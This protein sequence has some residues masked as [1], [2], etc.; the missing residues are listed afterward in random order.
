LKSVESNKSV[1]VV[2]NHL[3][4]ITGYRSVCEGLSDRL[5]KL[6]WNVFTTS[7]KYGRI[8]RLLDMLYTAWHRCN[9]Y[10]VATIDVFSGPAFWAVEL[11]SLLLQKLGKPFVLILHGGNL[12]QFASRYPIRVSRVLD[13]AVCVTSPSRYLLE[14]MRTFHSDIQLIPNPIDLSLYEFKVR[15]MPRPKLIWLRA[16]H[17]IYNPTLAPRILAQL[18]SDSPNT[19]LIMLGPDKGDGSLQETKQIANELGVLDRINFTGGVPKANVPKWLNEGDILINT[20]NVDNTPVSVIEAMACGLCVVSTDVGGIPYLLDHESD[21]LLVPP[22]NPK[23][24]AKAIKRI[25]NEP[26]LG[27]NLS[28]NARKKVEAFSW[29]NVLPM[30][31][32]LLQRIIHTY[33]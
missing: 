32:S 19:C 23:A 6:G 4:H 26:K 18:L 14:N 5:H 1:L 22:D 17:A 16:F 24:F 15:D 7:N 11:V 28:K 33:V 25:I 9:H 21:S 30:W 12:P 13:S 29:E 3:S 31:D 2:G 27:I 8:K 10:M 20:T